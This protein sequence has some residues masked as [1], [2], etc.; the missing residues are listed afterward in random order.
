MLTS[1]PNRYPSASSQALHVSENGQRGIQ[2]GAFSLDAIHALLDKTWA[3]L[4]SSVGEI[5]SELGGFKHE[6]K[7]DIDQVKIRI[8]KVED[9]MNL[10]AIRVKEL[11]GKV[12]TYTNPELEKNLVEIE[13]SIKNMLSTKPQGPSTPVSKSDFIAVVLNGFETIEEAEGPGKIWQNGTCR[14]P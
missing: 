6:V 11:E 5:K 8:S 7:T 9:N 13:P 4:H 14:S 2:K 10:S 12:D 3:R 1:Q